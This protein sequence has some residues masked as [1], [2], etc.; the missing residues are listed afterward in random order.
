MFIYVYII[1]KQYNMNTNEILLMLT[2]FLGLF[3][4]GCCIEYKNVHAKINKEK[5][6]VDQEIM[7]KE[8]NLNPF[9]LCEC[10]LPTWHPGRVKHKLECQKFWELNPSRTKEEL[11]EFEGF[12]NKFA[13]I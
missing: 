13:N 3:L 12:G 7:D 1:W 6:T 10:D 4:L 2:I 8:L 11:L 5:E 9:V